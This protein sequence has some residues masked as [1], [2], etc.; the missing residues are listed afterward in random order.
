VPLRCLLVDDNEHFLASAT[1]LLVSQG[2]EV[3]GCASSG[4]E[5]LR[6]AAALAPEVV[7]VDVQLGDEDGVALARQLS[8]LPAS[9]RVVLISTHSQDELE[10]DVFADGAIVGFVAK[11]ALS[12]DAIVTLLG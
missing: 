2:S 11:T 8:A 6:L 1:R 3:I 12:L 10:E 4:A 7:L 5:A 9:P